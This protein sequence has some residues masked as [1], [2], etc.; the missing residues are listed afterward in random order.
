MQIAAKAADDLQEHLENPLFPGRWYFGY[1]LPDG[2][3][4]YFEFREARS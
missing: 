1:D 2:G 4:C 3:R